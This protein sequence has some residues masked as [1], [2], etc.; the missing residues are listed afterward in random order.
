M[1]D[2]VYRA[3]RQASRLIRGRRALVLLYHR[4]AD[5]PSDP[6]GLCVTPAHFAEHLQAIRRLGT[7]MGLGE[8]L[9]GAR[10]GAV[11]DNAIC[12]TF[13]DGYLDNYTAAGPLLKAHGVPATIF[14][15]TG[16]DGREREWWWDELERVFLQP[17]ELPGRLEVE[18]GGRTHVWDLGDDRVYSSEQQAAHRGWHINDG[19]TPTGRHGVFRAV[20][21]VVQPLTQPERARVMD[22]L[23]AWGGLRADQVREARRA[24]TPEQARELVHGGLVT[25]GAHTLS[26]PALP[27]QPAD[28]K[29]SEIARSKRMLEA[30]VDGEVQGFAYPYG[31]YDDDT[32]AAVREAGFAYACA[33]DHGKVRRGCDLFLVPRI[34]VPPGDGD[35]LVGLFRAHLW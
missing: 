30:W 15:T 4:V 23:L 29:R 12:V 5:E 11:P 1:R 3:K 20:Y 19:N 6:F 28:A 10:S 35:S 31:L 13:D 7:P 8:V 34:D 26:H 24:M 2:V 17:G 27:S 14:F 21:R 25:A 22:H 33:G 16:A 32:V 9:A 18:F